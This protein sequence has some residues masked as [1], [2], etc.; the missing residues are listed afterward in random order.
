M[1]TQE[2]RENLLTGARLNPAQPSGVDSSWS[3]WSPMPALAPAFSADAAPSVPDAASLCVAGD[4]NRYCFGAWTQRVPIRPGAAYR[5]RVTLRCQGH[6]QDLVH[7]ACEHKA[8]TTAEL[9]G[10]ICHILAIPLRQH[11]PLHSRTLGCQYLLFH[12]PHR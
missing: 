11:H 3:P 9:G 7:G 10:N 6:R 8:Q 2:K 1:N 12:S 5:L 4:G